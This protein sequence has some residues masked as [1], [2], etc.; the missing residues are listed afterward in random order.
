MYV[1]LSRRLSVNYTHDFNLVGYGFQLIY[2][3]VRFWLTEIAIEKETPTRLLD[4]EL[5][6]CEQRLNIKIVI[7]F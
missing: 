7:E 1:D 4:E 2:F 3:R 5:D 6:Y